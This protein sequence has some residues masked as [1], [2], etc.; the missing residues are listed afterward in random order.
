MTR[1]ELRAIVLRNE[2]NC[3]ILQILHHVWIKSPTLAAETL[4]AGIL[5]NMTGLS[6]SDLEAALD[7]LQ[8]AALIDLDF[9]N[10]QWRITDDGISALGRQP[11]GRSVDDSKIEGKDKNKRKGMRRFTS[12]R[13]IVE[14]ARFTGSSAQAIE[15]VV[16]SP[17][18]EPTPDNPTGVYGQLGGGQTCI[19]GD[20]VVRR[21]ALD[22]KDGLIVVPGA[23][24]EMLFDPDCG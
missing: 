22:G 19:V 13:L 5:Q 10:R 23:L 11:A 14:A 21:H 4:P 3:R 17:V 8:W 24:F 2:D 16:V 9:S 15:G 6:S 18:L 1:I 20:Y 7:D 12:R